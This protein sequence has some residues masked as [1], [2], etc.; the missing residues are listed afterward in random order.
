VRSQ[1]AEALAYR[2]LLAHDDAGKPSKPAGR[3]RNGGSPAASCTMR[4]LGQRRRSARTPSRT[5]SSL[6]NDARDRRRSRRARL[7]SGRAAAPSALCRSVR[8]VYRSQPRRA[9]KPH[10]RSNHLTRA[11]RLPGHAH[12]WC[13]GRT[14]FDASSSG[15]RARARGA[16]AQR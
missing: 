15:E 16:C 7:G 1:I 5:S 11:H 8:A 4:M 10:L 2:E 13:S 12:L 14:S 6:A 3:R 9:R